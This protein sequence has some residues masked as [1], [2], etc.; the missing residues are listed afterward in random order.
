MNALLKLKESMEKEI[1]HESTVLDRFIREK[2]DQ[3][4]NIDRIRRQLS[5]KKDQYSL[6]NEAIKEAMS[7]QTV[8]TTRKS[9]DDIALEVYDHLT[10]NF[11]PGDIITSNHIPETFGPLA[12]RARL[13][14]YMENQGLVAQVS[15]SINK[16]LKFQLK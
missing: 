5:I 3:T 7:A 9:Q 8:K 12:R 15:G 2:P 1:S 16:F 10:L 14:R 11:A 4:Y 6:L 13:L